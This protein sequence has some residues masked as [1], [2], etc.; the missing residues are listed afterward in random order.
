L[1]GKGVASFLAPLQG[2]FYSSFAGV[3]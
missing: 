2:R 1:D 3:L